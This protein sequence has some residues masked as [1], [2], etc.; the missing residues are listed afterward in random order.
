MNGINLMKAILD[1]VILIDH[2]NGIG[3]ATDYI[4]THL[5]DLAITVITYA[6]VLTGFDETNVKLA[7]K[8][9][10][11]F[12][13]FDLKAEEAKLAAS[14]RREY[15]W[16][17]PDAFQYAIAKKHHCYLV[18]RNTKDFDPSKHKIIQVPYTI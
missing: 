4:D 14:L 7:N 17:L 10:T 9:L 13:I 3:Q 16:K 1:S 6:E 18:T 12:P 2:F 8:L 15:R 11:K 5:A